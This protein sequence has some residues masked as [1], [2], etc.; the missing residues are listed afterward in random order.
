MIP[1]T[2]TD[3]ERY[4]AENKRSVTMYVAGGMQ[5]RLNSVPIDGRIPLHVHK[6]NDHTAHVLNGIFE[7]TLFNPEGD[8]EMKTVKKGD[9]VL[10]EKMWHHLFIPLPVPDGWLKRW[11]VDCVWPEGLIL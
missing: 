3:Y 8:R 10:I 9:T 7:L 11:S 1:L 5:H 6:N 2:K 4:D